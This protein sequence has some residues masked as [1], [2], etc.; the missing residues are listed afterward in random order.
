MVILSENPYEIEKE[1]I[2]EIIV[3]RTIL[4]GRPYRSCKENILRQMIKGISL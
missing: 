3:E 4:K 1:K 2:G